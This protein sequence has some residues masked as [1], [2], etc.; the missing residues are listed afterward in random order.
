MDLSARV[1]LGLDA[2][3]GEMGDGQI[4]LQGGI[5]YSAKQTSTC[6]GCSGQETFYGLFPR[7]PARTGIS[8]RIRVPFWLIPGDLLVATPLLAFTSPETLASMGITAS[9]GGLIPWQAAFSTFLGRMQ[10]CLG[11]EVGATFYGYSG[12]EDR[13]F[14]VEES[15]GGA[16][17]VPISLRSID[18][19]APVLEIRPFRDFSTHQTTSLLFQLGVGADFPTKVTVLPPSEA[20]KPDLSPSYYGY[21]KLVFD[22]R[23]YF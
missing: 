18:V 22:W 17:L 8:T 1:G 7:M 21:V 16:V 20:A 2:L 9:N 23:R 13:L 6:T 10:F 4:F 5:S 12:G 15:P 11:R 3:L 14:A 19:E